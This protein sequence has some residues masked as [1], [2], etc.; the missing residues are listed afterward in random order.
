VIY[1]NPLTLLCKKRSK[2]KDRDKRMQLTEEIALA[3]SYGSA[4]EEAT[5]DRE[6]L[7]HP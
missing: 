3:A 4:G 1:E 2:E 6:R 7:T 5:R